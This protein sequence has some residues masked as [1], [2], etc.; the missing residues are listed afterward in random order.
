M[1]RRKR[2]Q[3]NVHD[4]GAISSAKQS[5]DDRGTLFLIRSCARMSEFST[6]RLRTGFLDMTWIVS[7][8]FLDQAVRGPWCSSRVWQHMGM[9]NGGYICQIHKK[10]CCQ[11]PLQNLAGLLLCLSLSCN[12]TR[13]PI[14]LPLEGLSPHFSS[15]L[16]KSLRKGRSQC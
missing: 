7:L 1:P 10:L 3:I 9:D 12:Y 4:V 11:W 13:V 14:S 16:A 8:V 2:L 15:T 5:A 6:P